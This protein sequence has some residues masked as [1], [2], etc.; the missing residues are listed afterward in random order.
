MRVA[1]ITP[2][3]KPQPEWLRQ[4]HESVL[5]QTHSCVHVLVA[6]GLPVPEPDS[7][8]AQH[9]ILA[10]NCNDYGDTP[11]AIGS[12]SAIGQGF[13]AIAFLDADNWYL[14][15]HIASLVELHDSTGADVCISH[16]DL[17]H[18]DGTRLGPCDE[19]DGERFADTS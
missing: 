10:G 1:V 12:M 14:P 2:Y 8:Q 6:D 17:Y 19:T 4:C 11:R 16:R 3:H 13:D 9:I 5:S 15:D 18:L 7:W